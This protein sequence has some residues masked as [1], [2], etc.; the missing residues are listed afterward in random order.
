MDR[1]GLNRVDMPG[2]G[3]PESSATTSRST[4]TSWVAISSALPNRALGSGSMAR[5]RKR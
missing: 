3:V 2:R 5:R 1:D 4:P